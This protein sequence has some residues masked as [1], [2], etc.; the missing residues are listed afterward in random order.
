MAMALHMVDRL[1]GRDLAVATAK[2]LDYMW[3]P[4]DGLVGRRS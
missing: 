4:D 3:D 2:Q 1:E